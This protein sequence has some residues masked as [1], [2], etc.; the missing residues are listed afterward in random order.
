MVSWRTML[1]VSNGP[2]G[3]LSLPLSFWAKSGDVT[4][5]ITAT[6]ANRYEACIRFTV[7]LIVREIERL[8]LAGVSGAGI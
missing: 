7:A 5:T 3:F 8:C 1:R 2:A 4:Q 6:A